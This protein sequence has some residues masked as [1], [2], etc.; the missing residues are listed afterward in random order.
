M[1]TLRQ[2]IEELFDAALELPTESRSGWLKEACSDQPELRAAVEHLLRAHAQGSGILDRSARS[3]V[4][5][6][7]PQDE[8]RQVGPYRIIRELGRGGMGVV[9][10]AVREDGQ[11]RQRVALKLLRGSP[12]AQE[13]NQRFRA[14]RQILASLQHSNIAQLLDGG[15]SDGRL[16]YLVMEY[17]EGLPITTYC[18]R[19]GLDLTARL[20]LFQVVCDAVQHAHKNLVLHRDLKPGN[21]LVTENGQVKLLDFGI[22]KLLN[23]ALSGVDLPLTRTEFRLMTPEYA[24][25]EQIRGDALSTAS[26]VYA[27]GVVFYE[28]LT[29][30]PPYRLTTRS[31]QELTELVFEREVDRP[32]NRVAAQSDDTG[33]R[34]RASTRVQLQRMLR[35]DL[36]AI[37]LKALRKEATQRYAGAEAFSQD[38]ERMLQGLPV[39]AQRGS[40]RYRIGKMLR[41]HHR[42]AAAA[43][44]VS[45]SILGG[46]SVAL[47]Q[48]GAARAQRNRAE[49]ALAESEQ[50]LR[51]SQL[52]TRSLISL[53]EAS[54][55]NVA[56][57]DEISARELMQRGLRQAESLEGQ[58]LLQ[59]AMF[60][61]IGGVQRSLG[62]I[63]DARVLLERAL[64]LRERH[65]GDD[66]LEVASS[67]FT[68]ADV[69]RYQGMYAQAEQRARRALNIR[70]KLLG[71]DH[72]DIAASLLQVS[73]LVIYR[74][75]LRAALDLAQQS[76]AMYERTLGENNEATNLSLLMMANVFRR[77]G[78]Y[79]EDEQ[80]NRTALERA[81]RTW[82][83]DH[84]QTA[85]PIAHL[86]YGLGEQSKRVAESDSLL[87]VALEMRRRAFGDHHV[88]IGYTYGDLAN[89]RMK[90][91]AYADAYELARQS[92]ELL[93]RLLG[94]RHFSMVFAKALLGR[95]LMALHRYDE[96]ERVF[97]DALALAE[98][99]FGPAHTSTAA[100]LKDLANVLTERGRLEE[101]ESALNRALA[102]REVVL[103]K[104]NFMIGNMQADLAEIFMRRRAFADAEAALLN[105]MAIL[106]RNG[107]KPAQY[108][109]RRLLEDLAQVYDATG[110]RADAARV[111]QQLASF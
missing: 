15:I 81:I 55:P 9:Y 102:I 67:L 28:L 59:A 97:R 94:P 87:Y 106:D 54:D 107:I 34:A 110:R 8:E 45:I 20:R 63:G 111:R 101:A 92:N 69:L 19:R 35:G 71:P 49:A 82:G 86:A 2:R 109:Y 26:D 7:K 25:P 96:A 93:E 6:L 44:V 83:P 30:E 85:R 79:A 46:A 50:A 38:I 73:G 88:V 10:L 56:G 108:D 29:G 40:R 64:A 42:L 4:Q 77:L 80:V 13:L 98:Q 5:R 78:Q 105:G 95:T 60:D 52:V 22:A 89:L 41:R 17:I 74:S 84:Q 91:G 72:P 31:P 61:A 104:N 62:Q 23:P 57:R 48:A 90:L 51:Q 36:D 76:V 18:D 21:I 65:R 14:E 53:F 1:N 37:A 11:F 43:A 103:G 47:W 58:P 33:A 99:V 32:S 27:L 68:L 75:D 39:Q 3:L 16:P 12:D 70:R 100:A 24:S 66:H